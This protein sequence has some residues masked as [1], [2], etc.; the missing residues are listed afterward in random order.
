MIDLT[1]LTNRELVNLLHA[2]DA[3]LLRRVAEGDRITTQVNNFFES[4]DRT[5]AL[6][7]QFV[8]KHERKAIRN[9]TAEGRNRG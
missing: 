5:N 1:A 8:T 6:L 4:L 3:E 7:V 2:A 9:A